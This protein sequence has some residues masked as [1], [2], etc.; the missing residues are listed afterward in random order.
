MITTLTKLERRVFTFSKQN[1]RESIR[2]NDTGDDIYVSVN[3]MN[4]VDY[5]AESG[6]ITPKVV[7]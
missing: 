1:L 2:F 5:E 7:S 3:F 6:K 4:Y